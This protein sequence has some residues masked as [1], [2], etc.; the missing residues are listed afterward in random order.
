MARLYEPG[1]RTWVHYNNNEDDGCFLS[2]RER[3]VGTKGVC[4]DSARL[5]GSAVLDHSKVRMWNFHYD[6]MKKIYR[7]LLLYQDTD[8]FAYLLPGSCPCEL[9]RR[10]PEWFDF[11]NGKDLGWVAN[12]NSGKPGYFKYEFIHKGD[13]NDPLNGQM[14]VAL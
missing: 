7:P 1:C 6:C 11:K 13:K 8:S 9:M 4:L 2:F 5:V 14:D 12:E 10:A 3:R